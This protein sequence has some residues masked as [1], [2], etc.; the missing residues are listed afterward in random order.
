MGNITET[1]N[2]A[3][4][5]FE[6][7]GVSSSGA[8][9]V[10]KSEVRAIGPLIE[11][12]IANAALGAL[13][14]VTKDTKANLDAD[15][16]HAANTIALVYADATDA[17][18]DLYI[19]SG[20][21][22]SGDWTNTGAL[23][24]ALDGYVLAD[25]LA[26][27]AAAASAE[28]LASDASA[29][30]DAAESYYNAIVAAATEIYGS[31]AAGISAT[32]D[33]E[34]FLVKGS[35]GAF[36]RLY[37]NASG[38]A[39]DQNLAMPSTGALPTYAAEYATLADAITAAGVN[40]VLIL[41][42]GATYEI[43][44][45]Q[46]SLAGQRI[47]GYGAT[48]KRRNQIVT[49]T[50]TA[51]TAG[52][53]S[54]VT[55]TSAA[56][57]AVGMQVAFAQQ[58]VARSALIY[59]MTLSAIRTITAVSG[60]Q[61]TLN[62]AVDINVSIGGTC[63]LT[64]VSLNLADNAAMVGVT[65]D[66]NRANWS[67]ARWEVTIEAGAASTGNNQNFLDCWFKDAP[68]EAI[69]PYGDDIRIVGNRFY[70]IGGNAIHL[71]G[72][73]GAIITGNIANNGNIDTAVGHADGFVS[74]SNGNSRVV[75]TGNKATNFIAGTGATNVTD[76]DVT[77]SENDFK[78]MYCFGIEGGGSATGL[79][80]T[81]NRIDGVATDT[82]KKPGSPYYG[83]IVFIALSSSDHLIAD[84]VVKNVSGSN[85]S[86]AISQVPG[87]SNLK[88]SDN[89][90]HGD[91]IFAGSYGASFS[92]NQVEG[93]VQVAGAV[94]KL[95]I[96]RNTIS[97]PNATSAISTTATAAYD[98]LE[99]EGNTI[100]GGTNGIDLTPS[101][102]AYTGVTVRGNKLYDQSNRAI[103]F[104]ACAGTLENIGITDNEVRVGASAGSSFIGIYN[105]NDKVTVARNRV[106][107]SIGAASRIAI[108]MA[109]A[110]TPTLLALDNEVRDAWAHTM[111]LT[112]NSGMYARGN[113]LKT[114]TATNPTG[115]NISGEV[116]F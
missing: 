9:D 104:P 42:P 85:K 33:G 14:D 43:S 7:D 102:T 110:S 101:G 10:V 53:T 79:T 49:T 13:V 44:A 48:I 57:F 39:V 115:N 99:I 96:N 78:S 23:H 27:E 73:A 54:T 31:T 26:A 94:S 83:G 97:Q 37:L 58:G 61:I 50:T 95:K 56:G 5:D 92:H 71:S 21:S 24:A 17:N 59:G 98:G 46:T 86:L 103:N 16:A 67:F 82:T 107:N 20:A 66:G 47:V 87:A 80:V 25:R 3:F 34:Y 30:A 1:I 52:V 88:M 77:I 68:G 72:V 105:G 63:F 106:S 62:S 91:V 109:G 28:A 12:A 114:K 36:A 81:G 41:Q 8:H 89:L 4:R 22:G 100:T 19:K 11:A 45:G 6:T 69:L 55:L 112:A 40:G 111:Y 76:S 38:V 2:G 51:M 93:R 70:D 84:N 74:F 75:I 65:F 90:L 29:N 60:N 113:L 64:F 15:L 32:T 35:G 116:V 18:N 108:Y